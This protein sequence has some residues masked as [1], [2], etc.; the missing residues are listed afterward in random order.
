MAFIVTVIELSLTEKLLDSDL[1]Y[2]TDDSGTSV[3]LTF[4]WHLEIH[5]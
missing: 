5:Y 2:Y 4:Q 1:S 3:T